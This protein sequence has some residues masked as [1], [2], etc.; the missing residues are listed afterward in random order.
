MEVKLKAKT[1]KGTE[2]LKKM[3]KDSYTKKTAF[4][5]IV[6]TL[7]TEEPYTIKITWSGVVIKALEKTP[8]GREQMLIG[9]KPLIPK[10]ECTEKD[11]EVI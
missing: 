8:M 10:Y 5:R 11:I 3:F 1:K 2:A 6:T 7:E 4:F 9:I